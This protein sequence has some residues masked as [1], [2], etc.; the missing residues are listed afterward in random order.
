MALKLVTPP[1][2]EP[3][4]LLELKKHLRIDSG[5]LEENLSSEQSIAAGSHAI[6][7][8]YSLEGA[9]V[10][11]LGSSVLVLLVAGACGSGGSVDIKL[12]ES[13][14][15]ISYID[16]SGGAFDP[17]TEANDNAV[18]E[19]AYAGD[20]QYLRAVG[21]VAGAACAFGVVVLRSSPVSMEDDLLTGFIKA[22]RE[23]CEGYQNRAFITQTWELLLD[24]FP[25]SPF[26]IPLPPLQS[27]ESNQI[28]S[29]KYYDTAG[30]E[31]EFAKA[32]YEVDTESYKGRVALAYGKSWPSV[33]LRP[34]NGVVVQFKAG[35]GD[36]A[37]DVP[38]LVQLAIKVLAGH[39]YENREATDTK[40]HLEVP[41]AV[42]SLLGLKR[43]VPI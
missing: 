24:A 28:E 9:G 43:I 14:D 33:T 36:A 4:S 6:A 40:E 19:F 32:N 29:I 16:V 27:D 1:A 17:V 13:A 7:A 22:A 31:T 3:V 38:E 41:F 20:K 2:V 12:Q 30:T 25:D 5:D 21:T 8:D 42:H 39:M 11:V 37:A 34:M 35:Y 15:D 26:Q 10:D 18:Y 23:Y